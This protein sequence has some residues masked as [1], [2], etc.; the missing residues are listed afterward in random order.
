[1]KKFRDID[2][3]SINESAFRIIGSE[4]MLLTAGDLGSFNTMTAAWG[5]FGTLWEKSVCFCF[6]RPPRY[7]HEY[8]EKS[9]V[10]SLC[11]FDEKYKDV[12]DFCGS[13]SGRDTDKVKATGISPVSGERGTVYFDEARLV[14]ICEKIYYQDIDPSHFIDSSIHEFYPEKDYHRMYVGKVVQALKK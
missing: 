3:Y 12:L 11:F 14:L 7:T 2:P 5:G 13:H 1:M 6:V 8:M 4:W 10:F 9:D